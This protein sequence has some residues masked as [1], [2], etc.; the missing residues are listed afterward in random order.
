M[1]EV[2]AVSPRFFFDERDLADLFYEFGPY[3]G[4]YVSN[5]P[6]DWIKELR[7]HLN[8]IEKNLSTLEKLRAN[9]LIRKFSEC[10]L[11]DNN[12]LD[13]NSQISWSLN[14][15]NEINKDRNVFTDV[16]GDV[17]ENDPE[18]KT[19]R[20]KI[21]QYREDRTRDSLTKVSIAEYIKILRPLLRISPAAYIIDPY[22][23]PTEPREISFLG[24]L[25]EQT[26]QSRCYKICLFLRKSEAL[27]INHQKK[28]RFTIEEYQSQLQDSLA[29]HIPKGKSLIINLVTE[30]SVR[31]HNR[32]FL[33]KFGGIDF[34]KGF[35]FDNNEKSLIPA[36]LMDKKTHFP[37]V[38]MFINEKN[39]YALIETIEI[40]K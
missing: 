14:V 38:D 17:Y 24:R 11:V 40:N 33:T 34:G 29:R 2:N 6:S 1:N 39:D 9:E 20:E 28:E 7:E 12:R 23:R 27:L 21:N 5:Y 22:F 15:R 26:S 37:L 32:Y 10:L 8:D 16:I 18:F 3:N 35:N 31:L 30:G 4:R 36:Y 25:F 19:W 13:Y